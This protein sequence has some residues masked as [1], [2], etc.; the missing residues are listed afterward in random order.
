MFAGEEESEEDDNEGNLTDGPTKVPA[1]ADL[2]TFWATIPG[3]AAIRNV[4]KGSWFIQ[5]LCDEI[6]EGHSR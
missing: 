6:E 4:N 1:T 2:L 5:A 3:Y